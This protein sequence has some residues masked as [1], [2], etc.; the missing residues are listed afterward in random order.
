MEFKDLGMNEHL[1]K[2]IEELK[3]EK[4]TEIQ[5][6]AIP[7]IMQGKDVIA[8]SAT[9]SGKTL[10]FAA[11]IVHDC[12]QKGQIQSLILTPTRELAEQI[13]K[14]LT[15]FSKYKYLRIVSVY[16]GLS[17][18]PQIEE[19]KRADVVV[20][21]P[22]RILD[23]LDR[24]TID[25]R[26]VK[27]L[28][29]DEA[30]R[31]FDMGF[32]DDVESI[33]R[34]CPRQRQTLLFSAT[35]PDEIKEIVRRHMIEPEEV[36]AEAYVDPSQLTQV[37]YE[38]DQGLKF[39]LLYHLIK[40]E[41]AHLIMV[42]CNSRNGVDFVTNNLVNLGISAT[43]I[44]GGFSQQKRNQTMEDFH[45]KKVYVLVCTD[46]AARGL[47]I[48][49]VSHVYNFDIPK[50]SKQYIHRIGRTARAGKDG[51]AVSFVTP[52][53]YDNF[54]R[55]LHDN[56]VK[57]TKED[58]PFVPRVNVVRLQMRSREYL[59]DNPHRPIPGRKIHERRNIKWDRGRTY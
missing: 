45:S 12:E 37:F 6:K 52:E 4:P 17:I 54:A 51:K 8:R 57:I 21:T 36:M 25:L 19:L 5:E 34:T 11:K 26:N 27:I 29:L 16:G 56:Q 7:L 44:H 42:F 9:G 55:V 3:F 58:K 41:K 47:D 10:V 43:A 1:M 30:D 15:E 22:G 40:H 38:L 32:V 28:V 59:N 46:V 33:I 13:N 2:A 24:R 39:S 35:I 20:G 23:H 48:K 53:D 50:D 31:M 14:A 18:N 49:G